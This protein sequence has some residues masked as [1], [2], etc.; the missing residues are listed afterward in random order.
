MKTI[1]NIR[2]RIVGLSSPELTHRDRAM[3]KPRN[4]SFEVVILEEL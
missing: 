2:Q 1:L 4:E 3:A